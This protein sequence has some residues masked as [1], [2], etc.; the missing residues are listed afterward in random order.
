[1]RSPITRRVAGPATAIAALALT[2][3]IAVAPALAATD[4]Q[5]IIVPGQA[6]QIQG[7]DQ[8]LPPLTAHLANS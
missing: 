5:P 3:L 6:T 4:V 2:G 7:V 8:R 1:M